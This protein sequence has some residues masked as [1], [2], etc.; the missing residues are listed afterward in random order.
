MQNVKVGTVTGTGSAINISLGWIPDY[1]KVI[2]YT[3]GDTVHEWFNGFTAGHAVKTT[4][5]VASLT[6]NGITA[7][8]GTT[9]A[10]AGFTIGTD[11][12]ESAKVLYYV[13]MRNP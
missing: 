9:S 8:A 11:V 6:S 2:N 12:S 5:A 1:V 4:T 13:A 10:A 7:Y 3:D